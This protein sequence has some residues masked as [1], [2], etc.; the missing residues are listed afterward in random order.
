MP[1]RAWRDRAAGGPTICSR[2]VLAWHQK[3]D[4]TTQFVLTV[5]V[6]P[7]D[8]SVCEKSHDDD[9]MDAVL[10]E[11]KMSVSNA[12]CPALTKYMASTK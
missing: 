6:G 9:L 4:G 10:L 1:V 8:A 3:S 7:L 2:S 12:G 5:F 11:R